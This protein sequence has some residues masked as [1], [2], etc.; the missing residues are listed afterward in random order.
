MTKPFLAIVLL[1]AGCTPTFSQTAGTD[2]VAVLTLTQAK[3]DQPL[4]AKRLQKAPR[5]D[6]IDVPY[7]HISPFTSEGLPEN[8]KPLGE[9]LPSKVQVSS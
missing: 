5:I 8:V 1:V 4:F 7:L 6:G 9:I 3:I 2:S